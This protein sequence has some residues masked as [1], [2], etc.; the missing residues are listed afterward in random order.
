MVNMCKSLED[1][2]AKALFRYSEFDASHR[3][4]IPLELKVDLICTH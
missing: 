4:S 1:D 2:E 3:P